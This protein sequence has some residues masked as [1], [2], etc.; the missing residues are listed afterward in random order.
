ME[1]S[2]A[3]LLNATDGFQCSEKIDKEAF[4]NLGDL[5]GEEESEF[6]LPVKFHV[7]L[8]L[9]KDNSIRYELEFGCRRPS[10]DALTQNEI[11]EDKEGEFEESAVDPNFFDKG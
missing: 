6:P 3:H 4:D 11:D 8:P 7:T 9:R 2:N 5:D 10:F 1:P